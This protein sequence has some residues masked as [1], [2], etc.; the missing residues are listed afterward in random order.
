MAMAVDLK[1]MHAIE[2]LDGWRTSR[3]PVDNKLAKRIHI[4]IH[5]LA[6]VLSSG[7]NRIYTQTNGSHTSLDGSTLS[8]RVAFTIEIIILLLVVRDIEECLFVFR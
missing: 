7:S 2:K 6:D 4:E 1:N 5:L 8:R 3:S